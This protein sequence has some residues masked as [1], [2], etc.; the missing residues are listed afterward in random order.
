MDT[1]LSSCH[2]SVPVLHAGLHF[3][4]EEKSEKKQTLSCV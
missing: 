3:V 1:A 2:V 4:N